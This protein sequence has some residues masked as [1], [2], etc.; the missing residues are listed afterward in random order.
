M[1]QGS[2]E[3]AL[4]DPK[5]PI[6]IE[7]FFGRRMKVTDKIT[8]QRQDFCPTPGQDDTVLL[9]GSQGRVFEAGW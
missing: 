4:A 1:G 9:I 2:Q 3:E 5:V 7:T 8:H 6:D